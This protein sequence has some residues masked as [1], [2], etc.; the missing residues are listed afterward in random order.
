MNYWCDS[1]ELFIAYIQS[2][3]RLNYQRGAAMKIETVSYLKQNA[4]NLEL[5]EPMIVTQNGKPKYVIEAYED[6]VARDEALALM[7]LVSFAEK[8]IEA[9]RVMD[10]DELRKRLRARLGG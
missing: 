4:A 9:G 8:D 7:K 6:R 3:L 2:K 1:R 5:D 10:G